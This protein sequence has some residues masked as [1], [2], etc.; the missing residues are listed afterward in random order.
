MNNGLACCFYSR[1][2]FCTTFVLKMRTIATGSTTVYQPEEM[3]VALYFL[4]NIALP[5][6]MRTEAAGPEVALF[7]YFQIKG[8]CICH[9]SLCL[10]VYS[11]N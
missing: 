11:H 5:C 1:F 9:L 7:C 8:V 6:I 10:L 3:L 4:L 2:K